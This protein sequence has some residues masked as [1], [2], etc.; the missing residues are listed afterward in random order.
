M[1]VRLMEH[2]PS[3]EHTETGIT[4]KA[5]KQENPKKEKASEKDLMLAC[6]ILPLK[7]AKQLG[8]YHYLSFSEWDG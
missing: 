8:K 4:L 2:T 1:C 7:R 3:W 5:N 6:H